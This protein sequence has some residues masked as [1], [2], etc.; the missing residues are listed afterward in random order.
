MVMM[1]LAT[2][3]PLSFF[4]NRP[5]R[6][7]HIWLCSQHIDHQAKR[8]GVMAR[9][10]REESPHFEDSILSYARAVKRRIKLKLEN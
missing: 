2:Y 5:I 10:K 4:R 1:N 6:Q 7:A 8:I 3:R 9:M